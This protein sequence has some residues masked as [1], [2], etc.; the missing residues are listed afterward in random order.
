M[1]DLSGA[2]EAERL[3]YDKR[4][5]QPA[6][7]LLALLFLLTITSI[8]ICFRELTVSV[9]SIAEGEEIDN[10]KITLSRPRT[11]GLIPSV[12]D[13]SLNGWRTNWLAVPEITAIGQQ[14]LEMGTGITEP[15]LG[16]VHGEFKTRSRV[17]DRRIEEMFQELC[18]ELRDGLHTLGGKMNAIDSKM[19]VMDPCC[20]SL[21]FSM[22]V[23]LPNE[24]HPR[25][26]Y[27]RMTRST[28]L[29]GNGVGKGPTMKDGFTTTRSR[30]CSSAN[31]QASFSASVF[32]SAYHIWWYS[33]TVQN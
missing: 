19:G 21:V 13:P 7:V 16:Q 33:R 8:M 32:A 1:V 3:G 12:G 4:G 20:C 14:A 26:S 23:A 17:T 22:P 30:M 9:F 31:F 15:Q 10:L 6:V 29:E 27:T 28:V 24:R 18:Q 25:V 5:A 2:F 11:E